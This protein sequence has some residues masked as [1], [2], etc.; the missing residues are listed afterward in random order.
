MLT[1][2]LE[3]KLQGQWLFVYLLTTVAPASRTVLG[4]LLL[5][6]MEQQDQIHPLTLKYWKTGQKSM[7]QWFATLGNR[8]HRTVIP[9]RRKT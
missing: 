4:R 2:A 9:K 3:C 5:D 8:Q 7:K 6:V 1:P